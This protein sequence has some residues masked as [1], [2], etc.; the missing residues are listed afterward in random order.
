MRVQ[1]RRGAWQTGERARLPPLVAQTC[2]GAYADFPAIPRRTCFD[3]GHRSASGI[4][5]LARLVVS[6]LVSTSQDGGLWHSRI[7]ASLVL[8]P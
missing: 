1:E 7:P 6:L 8:Q 2:H 5:G 4:A 3:R